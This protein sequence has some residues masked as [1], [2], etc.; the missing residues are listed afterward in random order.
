MVSM[1]EL[2]PKNFRRVP[3][4]SIIRQIEEIELQKNVEKIFGKQL[5]LIILSEQ[6]LLE[7][8]FHGTI[9]LEKILS[10]HVLETQVILLL[11]LC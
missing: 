3:E 10:L 9:S 7:A 8:G 1:N 5:W 4:M 2:I 6:H 11:Q